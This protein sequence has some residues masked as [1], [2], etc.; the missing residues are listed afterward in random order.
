MRAIDEMLGVHN[1]LGVILLFR[2]NDHHKVGA[3]KTLGSCG[4]HC[5]RAEEPQEEENSDENGEF[6]SSYGTQGH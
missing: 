1:F 5:G 4:E 6:Y 2:F 3:L